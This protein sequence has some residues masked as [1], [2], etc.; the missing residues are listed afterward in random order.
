MTL[1]LLCNEPVP[2]RCAPVFRIQASSWIDR[3]NFGPRTVDADP[4]AGIRLRWTCPFLAATPAER[5]GKPVAFVVER[6]GPL[7]RDAMIEF[8]P[9]VGHRSRTPTPAQLWEPLVRTDA[10]TFRV[11]GPDCSGVAAVSFTLP[12]NGTTT[13][14]TLIDVN[15]VAQ[16][17]ANISP[18]EDFHVEWADLKIVSFSIDAQVPEVLGLNLSGHTDAVRYDFTPIAEIAADIWWNLTLDEAAERVTNAA[19]VPFLSLV[20]GDWDEFRALGSSVDQ[21]METGAEAPS[22]VMG[23]ALI[24]ATRFEAAALMGWGFVDGDHAPAPRLDKIRGQLLT[25]P[26]DEV[27]VYRV[28]ARLQPPDN[29]AAIEEVSS[30]AFTLAS[31]APML[32]EPQCTVSMPPVSRSELTNAVRPGPQPDQ[33]EVFAAPDWRVTCT[34]QWELVSNPYMVDCVVTRPLAEDSVITGQPYVPA[35]NFMN[36]FNRPPSTLRGNRLVEQRQHRFDIPYFDS[37]VGCEADAWDFW[38]RRLSGGPAKLIQ[39]RI[40]YA[41]TA[42]PLFTARCVAPDNAR[43]AVVEFSLEQAVD[44]KLSWVADPLA[45]Y[46]R[47]SIALFMRDP[48]LSPAEADIELGPPSPTS[49]GQ[50][51]ADLHSSLAQQQL[52]CFVGGTLATGGF[53]ARILSMG[54]VSGGQAR[55]TFE[56]ITSCAGANLYGCPTG[57][58]AAQLWE[59]PQSMRLWMPLPGSIP[60][61]PVGKP[62]RYTITTDLPPLIASTTLFFA[63][64]LKF[65]FEG[66]DYKSKLTTPLPAPYIHPAPPAPSNC[67]GTQQLGT[68]YYGR[69]IV[70][71]EANACQP[72][73]P[74]YDM[75]VAVSAEFTEKQLDPDALLPPLET[76]PPTQDP[77]SVLEMFQA[78]KSD[79]IFGAQAPFEG[80]V[81]FDAFSRLTSFAENDRYM[82]GVCNVRKADSR[83]SPPALHT[84][85]LR[86]IE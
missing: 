6:S 44:P 73:E 4:Q 28:R 51:S 36:G 21:A 34:G 31:L 65:A 52:D 72:F 77:P 16:I 46:S 58:L 49:D 75:R 68:D 37:D 1:H 38:D 11:R 2:T 56:V 41:G 78:N 66:T 24:A 19:D 81:L 43:G 18:G 17:V 5:L 63:T 70:R 82:V 42:V 53:T 84:S 61:L 80:A 30:W 14:V 33:P 47:A 45:A 57:W 55:C 13:T 79:G 35:G 83:E 40:E 8:K 50:W 9:S 29:A 69:V 85:V 71:I 26:S 27:F 54:L 67:L 48:R 62:E 76:K 3:T 12:S 39:P 7:S 10:T 64:Q 20:P 32:A 60:V 25:G 59:D 15:G 86:R 22:A 23:L 74:R